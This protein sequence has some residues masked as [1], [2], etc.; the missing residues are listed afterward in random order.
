[1]KTALALCLALASPLAFAASRVPEFNIREI[2]WDVVI[3]IGVALIFGL[4]YYLIDAAPFIPAPFKQFIKYGL[5]VVAVLIVIFIILGF[6][7]M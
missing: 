1:M 2:V 7:G 6:L 5:L 3:L 4:L